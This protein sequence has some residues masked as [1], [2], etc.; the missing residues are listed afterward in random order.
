MEYPDNIINSV[1]ICEGD[2]GEFD[3]NQRLYLKPKCDIA[4]DYFLCYAPLF[5][6]LPG[7]RN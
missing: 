6:F 2:S 1:L 5:K 3:S 4:P 7:F